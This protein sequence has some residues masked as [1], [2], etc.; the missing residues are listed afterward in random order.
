MLPPS[1]NILSKGGKRPAVS[2]CGGP[3]SGARA[4]WH[5]RSLNP[6]VA[7]QP[8]RARAGWQ[9][10]NGWKS[11][12][13]APPARLVHLAGAAWRREGASAGAAPS[14]PAL[15]PSCAC[16]SDYCNAAVCGAPAQP[17]PWRRFGSVRCTTCAQ[18]WKQACWAQRR[19]RPSRPLLMPC[20]GASR[21]RALCCT[22]TRWIC[23]LTW[24]RCV[25]IVGAAGPPSGTPRRTTSSPA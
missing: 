5:P 24:P 11:Y 7:P 2:F 21:P 4:G 20:S 19:W 13:S 10:A 16:V 25:F 8:F 14:H 23:C 6:R 17:T 22:R 15:P 12:V 3:R 1:L 18:R 9:S